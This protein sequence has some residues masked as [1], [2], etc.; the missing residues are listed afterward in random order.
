M[1][2]TMFRA[3]SA[4]VGILVMGYMAWFAFLQLENFSESLVLL[5]WLSPLISAFV[6][7]YLGPSKKI[8]LGTSMAVP[9]AILAV[10]LNSF[11]QFLGN[12]VDFPGIQGGL[13][14]F[15][16]TLIYAGILSVIGSVLG[17]F[18]TR[19]SIG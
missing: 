4:G 3:W 13:I 12:A 11:D 6:S 9:A 19:K 2:S 15:A 7:S 8:L 16:T 1:K 5:L 17:Y 10:M 14:L 18:I